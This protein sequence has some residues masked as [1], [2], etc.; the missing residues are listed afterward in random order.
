MTRPFDDRARYHQPAAL[1]AAAAS[2]SDKPIG[3]FLDFL[4]PPTVSDVDATIYRAFG[5]EPPRG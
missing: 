2:H 1:V 5:L 4:I 3:Y